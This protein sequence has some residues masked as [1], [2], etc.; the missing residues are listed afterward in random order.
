M[1]FQ[2]QNLHGLT[3]RIA[4]A[5]ENLYQRRRRIA[6]GAVAGLALMLGYH[7]VCG[8]NGLTTFQQK[9]ME[10]KDLD[11]EV[12]RLSAENDRLKDHVERLKEDPGAIEHAARESLHYTRPDEVIYTL[13]ADPAKK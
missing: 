2:A 11:A 1:A 3:G 13:P 12:K 6:T 9:R 8:Q 10:A 5:G 4:R 7:V